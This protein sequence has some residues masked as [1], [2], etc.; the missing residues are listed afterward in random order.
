MAWY[1]QIISKLTIYKTTS[2][3]NFLLAHLEIPSS[4]KDHTK[5]FTTIIVW[6]SEIDYVEP[7]AIAVDKTFYW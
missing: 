2:C 7:H 4:S 3:I 6:I 5:F 1:L